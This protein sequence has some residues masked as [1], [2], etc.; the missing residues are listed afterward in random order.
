[1]V[2]GIK[3]YSIGVASIGQCCVAILAMAISSPMI[4]PVL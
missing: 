3:G 2:F 4:F 1:M